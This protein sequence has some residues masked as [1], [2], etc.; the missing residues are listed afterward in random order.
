MDADSTLSD[1]SQS[2]LIRPR[3]KFLAMKSLFQKCCQIFVCFNSRHFTWPEFTKKGTFCFLCFLI[4]GKCREYFRRIL[5]AAC[6]FAMR[7][8]DEVWFK[9]YQLITVLQ[10]WW[11]RYSLVIVRSIL[12]GIWLEILGTF[13]CYLSLHSRVDVWVSFKKI[14]LLAIHVS[15]FFM[16]CQTEDDRLSLCFHTGILI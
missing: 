14:I 15:Q 4:V 16:I 3:S 2:H 10:R 5:S 6:A 7:V 8:P 9:A 11:W 12:E 13:C 1:I